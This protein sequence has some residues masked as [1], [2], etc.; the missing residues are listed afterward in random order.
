LGIRRTPTRVHGI[1]RLFDRAMRILRRKAVFL[2]ACLLQA[3]SPITSRWLSSSV[4]ISISRSFRSES[5]RFSPWMEYCAVCLLMLR[6]QM[7]RFPLLPGK[8]R[9]AARALVA[10][11]PGGPRQGLIAPPAAATP[12][13]LAPQLIHRLREAAGRSESLSRARQPRLPIARWSRALRLLEPR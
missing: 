2:V 1:G 12:A 8:R 10:S 11:Q 13:P 6:S 4:P 7:P 3:I 5:S 9:K